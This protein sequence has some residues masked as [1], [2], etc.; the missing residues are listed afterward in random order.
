LEGLALLQESLILVPSQGHIVTVLLVVV[1][2][3]DTMIRRMLHD[4]LI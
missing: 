1:W 3:G 4:G 2:V